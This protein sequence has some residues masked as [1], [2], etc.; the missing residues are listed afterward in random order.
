MR[1]DQIVNSQKHEDSTQESSS[2]EEIKLGNHHP[3]E[4][5][6]DDDD[7]DDDDE[8][9]KKAPNLKGFARHLSFLVSRF[10]KKIL[11]KVGVID[12]DQADRSESDPR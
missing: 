6:D 2:A 7:D 5:D 11:N 9:E 3:A 4:R 10:G 1:H 8:D 12:W